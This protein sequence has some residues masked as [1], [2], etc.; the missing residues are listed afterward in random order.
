MV[1]VEVIPLGGLIGPVI[2]GDVLLGRNGDDD[3]GDAP[4]N[5][6]GPGRAV[7]PL[8]VGGRRE[9]GGIV[10]GGS[11]G[12]IRADGHLHRV[13][14]I[15]G[16][17]LDTAV[18]GE[19]ILLCGQGLNDCPV[20]RPLHRGLILPVG[21]DIA[22]DESERHRVVILG[23]DAGSVSGYRHFDGIKVVPGGGL[24]QAGVG[25]SSILRGDGNGDGVDGHRERGL[26][27]HALIGVSDVHRLASQRGE[28][29]IG[30]GVARRRGAG[31][32]R[33]LRG[34]HHAGGVEALQIVVAGLG[35]RS[36]HLN[37]GQHLF[38]RHGSAG[39]LGDP[40]LGIGDRD[41]RNAIRQYGGRDGIP[42]HIGSQAKGIAAGDHH[43]GGVKGLA[44]LVGCF[45]GRLGHGQTL[46]PER[47]VSAAG[48]GHDVEHL[49]DVRVVTHACTSS[50]TISTVRSASGGIS[51]WNVIWP[52]VVM[53]SALMPALP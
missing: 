18:R 10:A 53:S 34:H 47:A 51:Q 25:D 5:A 12:T 37:G 33:E 26:P 19:D 21:E 49:S 3:A 1:G 4:G 46:Q 28:G 50:R 45:V 24:L 15:P 2:G 38:H 20:D 6:L 11:A 9:C 8:V 14:A 48:A 41:L 17:G 13:I 22:I 44:G 32:V 30:V 23:I 39:G 40:S 52:V 29:R 31:T 16:G 43:A 35:G 7:P 42:R 36:S 27:A